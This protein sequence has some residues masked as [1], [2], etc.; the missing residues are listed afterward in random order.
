M[1][2]DLPVVSVI[3]PVYNAQDYLVQ[4]LDSLTQQTLKNIE[5]ICIN[6]GSTDQSSVILQRYAQKDLRIVLIQQDNAGPAVARN[7]GLAA[8][9]G[10]YLM[11]CDSD[12][13]FAL[14]AC[15]RMVATL[16]E[17]NVDLV[18]CDVMTARDD[19]NY[20]RGD[21]VFHALTLFGYYDLP[22]ERKYRVNSVLW[23]K[24]FK[25]E[26]ILQYDIRF[27]LSGIAEDSSFVFQ[28]TSVAKNV[29][30]LEEMLYYRR[31]RADSMIG[32]IHQGQINFDGLTTQKTNFD[33]LIRH[34]LWEQNTQYFLWSVFDVFINNIALFGLENR[35]R[36][37]DITHDLLKYIDFEALKENYAPNSV[38]GLKELAE[39]K[40]NNF[41]RY[42]PKRKKG[43]I[44][45]KEKYAD[46]VNLYLGNIKIISKIQDEYYKEI[47]IFGVRVY[48]KTN[49]ALMSFEYLK[50]IKRMLIK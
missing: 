44:F 38:R 6:D 45:T 8:A 12:D 48:K 32:K 43:L 29:F 40:E 50:Q 41:S 4:C 39:I 9:Q 17:A 30:G 15:E 23:N 35:Q 7:Q 1:T 22:D 49:Y 19:K 25:R 47:R 18:V 3:L 11:F 13:W 2:T 31:L 27:P 34:Q 36:C 28:Y 20:Q 14:D 21:E 37:L 26:L 46:L 24:I 10:Q 42:M 33:F 16:K 5:I